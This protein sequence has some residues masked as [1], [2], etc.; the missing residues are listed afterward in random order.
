MGSCCPS[1]IRLQAS[2]LFPGAGAGSEEGKMNTTLRVPVTVRGAQYMLTFL[3]LVF[4]SV[5][6]GTTTSHGFKTTAD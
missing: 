1:P 3:F 6:H 5:K 2:F 4:S